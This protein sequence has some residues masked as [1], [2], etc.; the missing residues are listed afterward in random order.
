M[1]ILDARI[2]RLA[3]AGPKPGS[4]EPFDRTGQTSGFDRFSIDWLPWRLYCNVRVC[5]RAFTLPEAPL[6]RGHE[7]RSLQRSFVQFVLLKSKFTQKLN[8]WLDFRLTIKNTV[9]NQNSVKWNTVLSLEAIHKHTSY[10][11]MAY[12]P[13]WLIFL[14]KRE[15]GTR[16]FRKAKNLDVCRTCSVIF[17]RAMALDLLSLGLSRSLG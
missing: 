1:P 15:V 16:I 3:L 6:P 2:R 4:P 13:K 11:E 8:K 5:M 14:L 12:F 7:R 17:L 9:I 10:V